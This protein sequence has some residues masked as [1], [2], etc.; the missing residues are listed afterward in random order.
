MSAH[1]YLCRRPG[2]RGDAADAVLAAA[3]GRFAIAV[4]LPRG[5]DDALASLPLAGFVEDMCT[6]Y[7]V[8]N[9]VNFELYAAAEP[10]PPPPPPAESD[11]RAPP[12]ASPGP[13]LRV[14]VH[15]GGN[16]LDQFRERL[17]DAVW[18]VLELVRTQLNLGPRAAGP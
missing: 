15:V 9:D 3:D 8:H 12:A 11:G 10:P 1:L 2:P 18:A 5:K 7:L 17:R 4:D 13:L 6:R 14:P 16:G